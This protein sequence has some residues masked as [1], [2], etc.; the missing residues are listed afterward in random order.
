MAVMIAACAVNAIAQ[1]VPPP[2]T[3][4]L[5][6]E[7]DDPNKWGERLGLRF[8]YVGTT[9]GISETFGGG[10][11]VS[12]HWVQSIREPFGLNF[13]L[14]AFAMGSTDRED[15]TL[16]YFGL[17]LDDVSMRIVHFSLGPMAEIPISER[18]RFQT[19]ARAGLYTVTLFVTQGLNQ[20]DPS[21]N[22]LGVNFTGGLVY[23]MSRNWFL[24][25]DL[26]LHKI[27]TS[28]DADDLF[29]VYSEGDTNP[30][31]YNVN[32]GLMLRLF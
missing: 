14:G 29:Y 31:F 22:H 3:P 15:I 21:D 24:D 1:E 27:F 16:S 12:L 23:R 13:A 17:N 4:A 26:Q 20:G 7:E 5:E 30:L 18:L 8:G 2:E 9:S 11:N 10:L 6:Q 28:E 25:I 19:A 32:I